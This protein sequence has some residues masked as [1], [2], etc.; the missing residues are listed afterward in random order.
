MAR[1]KRHY[2]PGYIWHTPDKQANQRQD[3]WAGSVAVGSK[4][5]TESVRE[6]LG[7]RAM[8]RDV[9][10]PRCAANQWLGSLSN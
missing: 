3:E 10:D 2:I 4:F 1:A 5:F 9:I 7:F 8:G 6:S